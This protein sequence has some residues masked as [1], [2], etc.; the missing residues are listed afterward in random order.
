MENF[1]NFVKSGA[2][3]EIVSYFYKIQSQAGDTVL[4][5]FVE[6]ALNF[7]TLSEKHI[8]NKLQQTQVDRFTVKS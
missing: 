8:N 6:H 2:R 1:K 5:E 3:R 7:F 4:I